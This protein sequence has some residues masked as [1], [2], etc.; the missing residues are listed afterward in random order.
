[1][2]IWR[3]P[4]SEGSCFPIRRDPNSKRPCLANPEWSQFGAALF[5]ANPE[6][7]QFGGSCFFLQS[8]RVAILPARK[9]PDSEWPCFLPIRNGHFLSFRRGH[10]SEG[11]CF[12]PIWKGHILSIRRGPN[13]E[14]PVFFQPGRLMFCQFGGVPIRRG[15]NFCQF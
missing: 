1:M 5:F 4:K 13:S 10:N 2:P 12:L 8:G 7:Y 11:S 15:P 9:G 14:S 3:G 6:G